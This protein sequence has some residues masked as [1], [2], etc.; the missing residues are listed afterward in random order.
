LG[1]ALDRIMHRVAEGT[2]RRFTERVAEALVDAP[3]R[4]ADS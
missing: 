3:V 2:V 1:A 4:T